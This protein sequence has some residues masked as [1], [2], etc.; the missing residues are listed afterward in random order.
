MKD[1]LLFSHD[2][3]GEYYEGAFGT[4]AEA[5]A[6]AVELWSRSRDSFSVKRTSDDDY[7][8]YASLG[9]R[10]DKRFLDWSD[11]KPT[12]ISGQKEK[13]AQFAKEA[14]ESAKARAALLKKRD[15]GAKLTIGER[16]ACS[17]YDAQAQMFE[18]LIS[19][20]K[21]FPWPDGAPLV[22]ASHPMPMY[23]APQ[24]P[25]EEQ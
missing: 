5:K 13:I 20:P 21:S 8:V 24:Q 1:F 4:L 22:S 10:R 3:D 16:M 11:E 6:R 2:C 9:W 15:S 7:G 23:P 17:M 18:N 12:D 25:T 14:K 19:Q